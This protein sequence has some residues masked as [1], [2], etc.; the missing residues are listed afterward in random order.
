MAETFYLIQAVRI[1]ERRLIPPSFIMLQYQLLFVYLQYVQFKLREETWG[2]RGKRTHLSREE[3]WK[4]TTTNNWRISEE[5]RRVMPCSWGKHTDSVCVCQGK[6]KMGGNVSHKKSSRQASSRSHTR[7]VK[8]LTCLKVIS[9]H[10]KEK[11]LSVL[12]RCLKMLF[13]SW[14]SEWGIWP[15]P[16]D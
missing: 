5:Y 3:T 1:R 6:L 15:L 16:H 14:T 10:I 12:N 4:Q 8:T 11:L 2:G 9:L 7:W 13:F